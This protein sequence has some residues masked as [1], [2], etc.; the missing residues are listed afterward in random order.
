MNKVLPEGV[1]RAVT[2]G[3]I[4]VSFSLLSLFSM[5][6]SAVAATVLSESFGV[7]SNQNDIP[8]WEKHEQGTIAR[9]GQGAGEDIASPNGGRFAKIAEDGSDNGNED[10][11]I[12]REVNAEQY[13]SLT[14][15]Y[16]WNGDKDASSNDKGIVEARNNGNGDANCGANGGW[17]QLKS[18]SLSD[19]TP[20]W[21]T[22]TAFSIG[23]FDGTTFLIRFRN[24]ANDNEY[25]RV[26]GIQIEGEQAPGKVVVKKVLINNNGGSKILSE[27]TFSVSGGTPA[28]LP[29]TVEGATSTLPAGSP[30]TV[31]ENESYSA[32]LTT[33]SA[34]CSGTVASGE[35]KYCIV[36][37]DDIQQN[38]EEDE[39]EEG[40]DPTPTP[41]QCKVTQTIVS[42]AL[43]IDDAGPATL[44][45]FIHSAWTALIAD[46]SWIWSEEPLGDPVNEVTE[47]FIRD[48]TVAGI[49]MGG[50]LSIAADNSYEVILNGLP[51]C[52]DAGED[53]F[54][55]VDTCLIDA[56]DL[57][58]GENTIEFTV[59][60][61]AQNG[62]TQ[63]TNPAGLLYKLVV[64]E[65]NCG[66]TVSATKII[67]ANEAD[68]PNY[69]Y[70]GD[71][72]SAQ[73]VTNFPITETTAADFLAEHP[74]CWLGEGWSWQW[75][76]M[77]EPALPMDFIG[78][79]PLPWT[80]YTDDDNDGV[81]TFSL[82]ANVI[83]TGAIWIREV[84]KEGYMTFGGDNPTAEVSPE[85]HCGPTSQHFDNRDGNY[86]NGTPI[87]CVAWNVILD[88][89]QC[90]DGINNE[91]GDQV[92]DMDDPGCHTDGNPN[93]PD[94]Y[95]PKDDDESNPGGGQE[96]AISATKIICAYEEDLPNY[97]LGGDGEGAQAVT[98]FPITET[99]AADFLEKHPNCWLGEGW[100]WQWAP[101]SEPA[102]P[103]NLI[104]EAPDPWITLTD[105][106]NDGVTEFTLDPGIIGTASIWI[107][108]VFLAG[109]VPFGGDNVFN[110]VSSEMHCGPTSQHFDNRDGNGLN[111]TP[112]HCVAWNALQCDEGEVASVEEQ[113]C[114]PMDH[115]DEPEPEDPSWLTIIKS[116][117]GGDGTFSFSVDAL[118][119]LEFSDDISTTTLQGAGYL[120]LE[121]P[122][123]GTYWVTEDVAEEWTLDDVICYYDDTSE[124]IDVANGK[125]ITVD[126]AGDD[127]TC[128]FYNSK[129]EVEIDDTPQDDI[130]PPAVD[131]CNNI[132]GVQTTVPA[133]LTE[134]NNVCVPAG[135]NN[136]NGGGGN[137][138]GGGGGITGLFAPNGQVAGAATQ[139]GQV[140]GETCGLYM[141]QYLRRG[142]VRNN[143]NQVMK[144]QQFLNKHG[145]GTFVPSGFF[146]P[147]TENA[148]KAFQSQYAASILTPWGLSA[149]TGLAY[150]TTLRQINLIE[151][152]ALK[153]ELPQLVDWSSNPTVQ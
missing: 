35:V 110:P 132:D 140:L 79:A 99:T 3:I 124:G 50:T 71:G 74:K 92:S 97:G 95:D 109:F 101:M 52:S 115:E 153:L 77:S 117:E 65:S 62:G 39:D 125:Q 49:P 128:Y 25:F 102:L 27:F 70:G 38:Q 6:H 100:S 60:N 116:T 113:A 51:L 152:P 91:D 10:G 78:P 94:S 85:M 130:N 44:L 123:A 55:S 9:E 36:T 1:G 47:N 59:K 133:G 147:M 45:T 98:N 20:A 108:E 42:D 120:S 24:D 72:E 136:G 31:V 127:I 82:A 40:E 141:D 43:T 21:N 53:N 41:D 111:G 29:A 76:P 63:E 4:A 32:Y 145:F 2:L 8:S 144:L 149:P 33:Y 114:V 54:S 105:D 139:Q 107:R 18:H 56:S 58:Q 15:T 80:T 89:P 131:L 126:E 118:G 148:V 22:Q 112:I 67:C 143:Q 30:Y 68:L 48:F 119:E 129:N 17:T 73:P 83:G 106:D 5:P 138:A 37:N 104:G 96:T 28:L 13:T 87:H 12:C 14:L 134:A 88:A 135:P 23:A 61:W 19:D 90:S 64:D 57:V 103:L 69:G 84:L 46:A 26:D 7:G 75:A 122:G 86:L 150:L 137:G 142:N 121:L 11:W 81:T 146:G 93:N 66:S 16:Y 151:C 34:D